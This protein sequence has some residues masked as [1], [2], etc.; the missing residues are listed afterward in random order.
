[1]FEKSN[2]Y[3]SGKI[4]EDIII[5]YLELIKNEKIL[6]T[7]NDKYFD[8]MTENNI[9]YEIKTQYHTIYSGWVALEFQ[10]FNKPSGIVTTKCDIFVYLIP[11][12][13]ND[14][15]TIYEIDTHNLKLYIQTNKTNI[16]IKKS[17]NHCDAIDNKFED[18]Y[19]KIRIDELKK[20]C[21]CNYEINDKDV[22]YNSFKQ[23]FYE[24]KRIRN[25]INNK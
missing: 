24:C 21:S 25:N 10:T 5:K 17:V 23:F 20:I 13:V 18:K 4:G 14:I 9:K 1:M 15:F 6:L 16:G 3:K 8:V 7:C 22:H 19:Y 11:D 2:I 12:L